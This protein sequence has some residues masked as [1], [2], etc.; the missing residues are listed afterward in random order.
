[1]AKRQNRSGAAINTAAAIAGRAIGQVAEAIDALQAQHP[2]PVREAQEAFAEGVDKLAAE[3]QARKTAAVA[4][5]RAVVQRAR[6]IATRAGS[7]TAE[8]LTGAK[9]TAQNAVTRTAQNVVSRAKSAVQLRKPATATAARSRKAAPKAKKSATRSRPK[10]AAAG[11]AA[12]RQ[13]S[14]RKPAAAGRGLKAAGL[15]RRQAH[16]S[17][18]GQR[19][20]ARRDRKG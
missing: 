4:E 10:A 12:K 15:R 18:Q 6:K 17:S 16:A 7:R 20:Q 5:T 3:A 19:R 1:M 2:H 9:R 8:V 14:A 13:V 11:T